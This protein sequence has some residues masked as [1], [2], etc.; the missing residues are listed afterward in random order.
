MPCWR[1]TNSFYILSWYEEYKSYSSNWFKTSVDHKSPKRVQLFQGQR[2]DPA[3]ARL[4]MIFI[5]YRQIETISDG[6]EIT[7]NKVIK[8][9]LDKLKIFVKEQLEIWY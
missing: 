9:I 7:V 6:H 8:K 3:N 2:N 4:F 5:R 1:I